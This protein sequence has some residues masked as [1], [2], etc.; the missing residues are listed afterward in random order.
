M[1]NAN[2]EDVFSAPS[3]DTPI[4]VP[5]AGDSTDFSGYSH[6]TKMIDKNTRVEWYTTPDIVKEAAAWYDPSDIATLNFAGEKVSGII[7]KGTVGSAL[8]LGLRS[9]SRGG[10]V[11]T[12][13]AFNGAYSLYFNNAS[14]YRSNGFFPDSLPASGPRTLFVLVHGTGVG[15]LSVAQAN[16]KDEGRSLLLADGGQGKAYQ[17]GCKDSG[18]WSKGK[19]NFSYSYDKPCV[20]SGRTMPIGGDTNEVKSCVLDAEGNTNGESKNFY[21]PSDGVGLQFKSYYGTFDVGYWSSDTTGYQGEAL[22]FTKAL[23]DAEMDEVNAYLKTKWLLATEPVMTDVDHL[24]VDATVNL[25]GGTATFATLS[26][27]GSFVNGTVVLTGELIV[28]VNADGSVNAPSF[29]KLVLGNGA[30]LV[31]KGARHLKSSAMIQLV[32]FNSLQG[33]FASAV[34]EGGVLLK[35]VY[36]NNI[37]ACRAPGMRVYIR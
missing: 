25:S 21:M 16:D 14:G 19:A 28:T 32:T 9:E 18:S 22:I 27:S 7:N 35:V 23:T 29:D 3:A 12:N 30:S 33:T 5:Y 6:I 15:F 36:A 8:D 10:A 13:T 11:V 1:E 20:I 17:I 34:G 26:G 37:E 31:V 4:C 2:G 24:V